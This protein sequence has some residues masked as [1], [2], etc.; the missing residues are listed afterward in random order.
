MTQL[1]SRERVLRTFNRQETDRIPV[2]EQFWDETITKWIQQGYLRDKETPE[3]HFGFDMMG[4]WP[5]D[6]AADLDVGEQIIEETCETKLVRNG[7][8]AILRF[9][10]NKSGTPEHVDFEVKDR[11]G[12]EVKIRPLLMDKSLY[13]RRIW[14]KANYDYK[15]IRDKAQQQNKFFVWQG[16]NVFESIHPV[17][18]HEYML[19]GMAL[20]PDWVKDMCDVYSTLIIDLM[21]LLFKKEGKPDGIFFFEDMGFKFKPFMSPQMYNEIIRPA[22][23]KTIDY[24]HSIGIPIIMH[25]C[26]YVEPLIP[27][28]IEMGLDCL[29]AMEAKAGMDVINLKKKFGD[30]LVLFGGLDIRVLETNDIEQIASYM[31]EKIPQL[32]KGGGYILHTDHSIPET[33]DYQT[34][35]NFVEI[36]LEFGKYE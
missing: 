16:V 2:Y 9:W 35:K 12:W 36:G 29:Q 23:K 20:D 6:L 3:E 25:S 13:A 22:H 1:N 28:L 14:N 27:A 17:C 32:K 7:N 21:K 30:K 10:K 24:A 11:K 19:I 26:G 8:G 15:D 18:G 4:S 33:V 31:Q 5:F 34:Y